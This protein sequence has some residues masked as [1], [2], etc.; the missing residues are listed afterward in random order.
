[1]IYASVCFSV[2]FYNVEIPNLSLTGF[3]D[4]FSSKKMQDVQNNLFSTTIYYV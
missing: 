2:L 3:H 4:V 1:M